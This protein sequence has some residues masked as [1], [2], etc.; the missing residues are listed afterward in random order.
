MKTKIPTLVRLDHDGGI[1]LFFPTQKEYG[2]RVG[3]WQHIGQH[4]EASIDYVK[5]CKN[6]KDSDI[7]EAAIKSYVAEY[8]DD[9]NVEYVLVKRLNQ[10]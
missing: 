8:P 3:C 4:G 1:I 9:E 6:V 2:N 5:R 10:K 7:A